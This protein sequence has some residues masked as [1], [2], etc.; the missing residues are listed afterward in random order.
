MHLIA[1]DDSAFT[2]AEHAAIA[3]A[4]AASLADQPPDHELRLALAESQ[5]YYLSHQ[6]EWQDH[7]TRME[8]ALSESWQLDVAARR[9]CASSRW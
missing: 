7:S 1:V 3:D 6:A 9:S 4:L 5:A 2:P 8:S